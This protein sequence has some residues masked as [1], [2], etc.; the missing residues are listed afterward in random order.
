MFHI[1]CN[2]Q[3]GWGSQMLT[4]DYEG[5]GRDIRPNSVPASISGYGPV[6]ELIRGKFQKDIY[7][8]I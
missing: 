2:Q 4:V 6:E 1:L 8:V 3:E 5:H 7:Y